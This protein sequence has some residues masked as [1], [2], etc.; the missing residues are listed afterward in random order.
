M[1]NKTWFPNVL[2]SAFAPNQP[3]RFLLLL[4]FILQ[5]FRAIITKEEIF[6]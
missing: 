2:K 3:M 1:K 4:M 6:S 5:F